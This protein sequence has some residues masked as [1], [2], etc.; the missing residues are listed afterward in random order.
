MLKIVVCF[1]LCDLPAS[2]VYVPTFQNL[3]AHENGADSVLKRWHINFRRWQITQKKAY[4]IQNTA[5]V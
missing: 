3:P 1:L 4:N 2:E 5:K